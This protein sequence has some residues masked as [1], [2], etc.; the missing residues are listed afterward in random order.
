M[1]NIQAQIDAL[2]VSIQVLDN[3]VSNVT[4]NTL[5]NYNQLSR[6][7]AQQGNVYN[8]IYYGTS[9]ITTNSLTVSSNVYL[10][11]SP[12]TYIN[13]DS[14]ILFSNIYNNSN[15]NFVVLGGANTTTGTYVYPNGSMSI[16]K[17]TLTSGYVLD[18]NGNQLLNGTV[19]TTNTTDTTTIGTGSFRTS[20][21]LS[22]SKNANVGAN[23]SSG[24]LISRSDIY[25]LS[26]TIGNVSTYA[27]FLNKTIG[28]SNIGCSITNSGT[29]NTSIQPEQ[30]GTAYKNLY[31]NPLGGT[32]SV[33]SNILPN[34]TDI[35]YV[36][37]T[38]NITGDLTADNALYADSTNNRVG[39]NN[40]N[41]QQTLDVAGVANISVDAFI[42]NNM[43]IGATVA[44]ANLDVVGNA[45]VSGNLNVDNGTLWVD[46]VNDRVGILNINPQQA[47]DIAGSAN[48]SVN[49]FI[50]NNMAIGSTTA[51]ANLDVTGNTV[52]RGNLNVD[53]GTF[54]IDATNNRVG[55]LNTNPLQALD[56]KGS[57]NVSVN[58]FIRNN[59]GIG[60]TSASANVDVTGNARIS[61]NVNVGSG[62]FWINPTVSRIGILNTNPQYTLD[63]KGDSNISGNTIMSANAN[64]IGNIGITGNIIGTS[65]LI[66]L[67]GSIGV[68]IVNPQEA[69]DVAGSANISVDT[70]VRNNLAVGSTSASANVDI[71]GNARISGNVNLNNGTLWVDSTN[72][73][74]GIK[75]TNPLQ[76][77]DVVGSAN[78]SVNTFVRNN[79]A[80]GST[81]ASANVDITGNA[82]ISG[83]VN[84]G[85]GLFWINPT[86]NRIGILNTNPQYA[87][88]IAG[89][90]NIT[91][92]TI[93]NANAN[94]IGNLGVTGNIIGTSNLILLN[95]N[96]GIGTSFPKFK[97]DVAGGAN[98]TS[99]SI[100]NANANILGN[101]GV[102]G[103]IIGTSNLIILNGSI[104]I[105]KSNPAFDLDV[106]GNINLTGSLYQN[107]TPFSGTTQWTTN[108][109]NIYYNGGN[110]GIGTATPLAI[111]DVGGNS[112]IT[113]NV[114][115]G[116][117]LLWA[118][119]LTNRI[120]VLNTNPQYTMDI[121][122]DSNISANIYC[123]GISTDSTQTPLKIL[124]GNITT[125]SSGYYNFAWTQF[126]NTPY[127]VL[128]AIDNQTNM[129]NC[130]IR[131]ISNT[132]ANV[133]VVDTTNGGVAVIVNYIVMGY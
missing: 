66:L 54:W 42:R 76:A 124:S 108:G 119:P 44:S 88:D 4:G 53:S 56:I 6:I 67:N 82:R 106:T 8:S 127:L 99:A 115:I 3:T 114:N 20:G 50:R 72:G 131:T 123:N 116:N 30:Q 39:I 128:T 36:A 62:L 28:T 41:P 16:N 63:I 70:F 19:V 85:S 25:S 40:L 29:G 15:I 11:N 89:S 105:K 60:S 90:A 118:N 110:V 10:T 83:N 120:G 13:N 65:N 68:G 12:N 101:L 32:V 86:V 14:N 111:L 27:L 87:L 26:G 95:G 96:I 91:S 22:V 103:N 79:L 17:N 84:V 77:L 24:N 93:M 59:L 98:I 92:N 49:A 38:A 113:G 5:S 46:D 9:S 47:L 126:I 52:I 73:R 45:R 133:R 55:V 125:N 80:V 102:T 100:F 7:V 58:T 35:L 31:L 61:G 37:G 74:I 78:I 64:V 18:I 104:G 21:G 81:S 23:I 130:F 109:S 1:S 48:V 94:V 71:T 51:N 97:L 107:G 2:A 57:A 75:N 121:K 43:A 69:L 112:R 129:R 122:G 132:A 34:S 117:G 33:G